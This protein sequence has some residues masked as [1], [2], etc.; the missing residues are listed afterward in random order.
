MLFSQRK[1]YKPVSNLIQNDTMSD[2]LRNTLWN[3]LDL[4]VWQKKDFLSTRFN[5]ER[6][7]MDEFSTILWLNYFKR[8]IDARPSSSYETK[9]VI[10]KYFF[11]CTWYEVYD[12]VQFTLTY[13]KDDELTEIVNGT[14]EQ[15]LSAYRYVDNIFTD[16]TDEQEIKMLEE[17]LNDGDFPAVVKHLRRALELLS[18]RE[19][20]DYRNSIKESIS[21]VESLAKI[22]T[23]KPKATLGQA[24]SV[25]EQKGKFHPA[26]LEAFSKLYGYASNEDGIRHAMLE[27]PNLTASD[28]KFFLIS[29]T[30]FINYLKSKL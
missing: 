6:T 25:L 21:A 1:G 15:E 14:L 27:D 8:P 3:I 23:G 17:A 11:S 24:L 2:E 19:K 22:I 4:L 7:G 30:S 18:D 16:I 26:L 20:P 9:D 29:C 13:F 10:R 12:F 28:A 5:N